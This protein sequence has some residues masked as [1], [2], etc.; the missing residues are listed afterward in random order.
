[1]KY[2]LLK[3]NWDYADEFNVYGI[4]IMP[5]RE[6]LD[7]LKKTKEFFEANPGKT[8]EA[9][10]GTNEKIIYHSFKHWNDGIEVHEISESELETFK[11]FFGFYEY[12]AGGISIHYGTAPY[13]SCVLE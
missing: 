13:V 11:K 2:V 8:V 12:T 1:M 6:W 3:T 4:E 9:Y 5:E 10:F 7:I